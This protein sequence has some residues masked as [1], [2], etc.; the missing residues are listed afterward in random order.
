MTEQLELDVVRLPREQWPPQIRDEEWAASYT[1]DADTCAGV[2]TLTYEHLA[3]VTFRAG[4][5]ALARVIGAAEYR[6]GVLEMARLERAEDLQGMKTYGRAWIA[7]LTGIAEG[8][9]E[10]G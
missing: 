8:P 3:R 2:R 7:R 6:A 10:E 1:Q 5:D 4:N 9:G